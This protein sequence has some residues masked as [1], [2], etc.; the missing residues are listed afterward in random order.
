[1]ASLIKR[2]K[3]MLK[4]F[5]EKI[6]VMFNYVHSGVVHIKASKGNRVREISL[7]Y[8][9]NRVESNPER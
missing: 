1:M 9:L 7:N 5:I 8:R 4:I 2:V 6:W 3:M